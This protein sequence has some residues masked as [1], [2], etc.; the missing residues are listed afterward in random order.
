[1]ATFRLTPERFAELQAKNK[2]QVGRLL[3]GKPPL[4]LDKLIFRL[5]YPPTANTMFPTGKNGRRFLSGKGKDFRAEVIAL[6][7][8]RKPLEGRLEVQI[9]LYPPDNR[10]RDIDNITKSALDSLTA[11]NVWNDDSQI[12]R[13]IINR[14]GLGNHC[15][16]TV[17][18]L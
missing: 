11:A 15:D 6:V 4:I 18:E 16:V 8:P 9:D 1:M 17:R 5:P 14:G 12:D 7:G 3:G 2:V 13:L 10:R